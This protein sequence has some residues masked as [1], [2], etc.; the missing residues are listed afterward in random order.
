M[1]SETMW[2]GGRM[3]STLLIPVVSIE[4]GSVWPPRKLTIY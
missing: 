4:L 1:E 3:L 2:I